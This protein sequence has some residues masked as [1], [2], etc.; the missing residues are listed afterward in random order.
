MQFH[1]RIDGFFE[2]ITYQKPIVLEYSS[3]LF[4]TSQLS[5]V[6]PET[7]KADAVKLK[8][9]LEKFTL[10]VYQEATK[11]LATY[12]KCYTSDPLYCK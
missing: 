12:G 7:P 11:E 9:F 10:D 4:F 3:H 6:E 5:E 1:I 8:A 2:D